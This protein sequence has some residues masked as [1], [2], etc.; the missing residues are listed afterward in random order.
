MIGIIKICLKSKSNETS[1][2]Y[3]IE[4]IC[5][6]IYVYVFALEHN[7]LFAT[8]IFIGISVRKFGISDERISGMETLCTRIH[9]YARKQD[10]RDTNGGIDL[11]SGIHMYVYGLGGKINTCKAVAKK[12]STILY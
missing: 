7:L 4:F 2:L 6:C 3:I 10:Y 11:F 1:L 12:I 9:V 5:V 8:F